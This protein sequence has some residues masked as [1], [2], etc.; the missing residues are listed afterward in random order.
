MARIIVRGIDN[1]TKKTDLAHLCYKRGDIVEVLED[2]EDAGSRVVPPKFYIIEVPDVPAEK[3][4][5]LKEQ[6]TTPEYEK[7]L[8]TGEKVMQADILKMRKYRVDLDGDE[9]V[10]DKT[11]ATK[12]SFEQ[13]KTKVLAEEP[14]KKG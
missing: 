12:E 5:Y 6:E 1:T 9:R 14:I 13:I 11:T 8:E 4:K 10:E 3:L 2:G 7:T